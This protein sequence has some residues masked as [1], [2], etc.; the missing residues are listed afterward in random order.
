MTGAG[1][2]TGRKTSAFLFFLP[3]FSFVSASR[4]YRPRPPPPS[5]NGTCLFSCAPCHTPR[6][7]S[8][9]SFFSLAAMSKLVAYPPLSIS[10]V[11]CCSFLRARIRSVLFC[12]GSRQSARSMPSLSA[13]PP[14]MLSSAGKKRQGE[15]A[16]SPRPRTKT[17]AN[18][19]SIFSPFALKIVLPFPSG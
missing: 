10:A 9:L 3:S 16:F 7:A 13:S 8:A 4:H 1:S 2:R 17:N 12:A 19:A 11:A 18:G 15:R 6:N 14:P 5:W